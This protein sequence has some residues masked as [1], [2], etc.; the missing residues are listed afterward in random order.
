MIVISALVAVIAAVLL[1]PVLSDLLALVAPRRAGAPAADAT[2]AA[3][4]PRLVFLVPAHDEELLI[5]N[6]IA[7]L[8]AM[9]YP[10]GHR[11]VVVI[12]DNCSDDTAEVARRAGAEV[13]ERREPTLPGKPRALA[14]ALGQLSATPYDAVVVVDAD[15]VVDRGFA[16]ALAA[17]GPLRERA[18]QTCNDIRNPTENALTRMTATH[19]RIR[20]VYMNGLKARAGLPVPLSNGLC[21][22]R[23]VV[24]RWGWDAFSICE[25][26]EMY[27]LLTRRGVPIGCVPQARTF[28]Q[29]AR[30][31]KQSASQ[32]R[33][34]AAGKLTVLIDHLPALLRAPGIAWRHKLDVAAELTSSGPA[35]HAGLVALLVALVLVI[36][37]PGSRWL[38]AALLVSVARLAAYTAWS[39]LQDP[40]PLRAMAAFLYFPLYASWRLAVQVGAFRMV[41]DRPWIRT[42]RHAAADVD[43]PTTTRSTPW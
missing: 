40:Q 30:T 24:D 32:R 22:G 6:T 21:L 15:A 10:P 36:D 34:W 17:A 35:V 14:W 4:P 2:G 13:L 1:L 25:D 19:A 29:E 26:W 16:R 28:A 8:L 38:T 33:R 9:D 11:R 20:N 43:S 18:V 23:A 27:V 3:D 41:G 39:V 42:E 12:A 31:L 5:G 7:S 37:P